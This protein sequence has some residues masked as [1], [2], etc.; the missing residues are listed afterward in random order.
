MGLYAPFRSLIRNLPVALDFSFSAMAA[1]SDADP[2]RWRRP[3][4]F[5]LSAIEKRWAI[6]LLL[7]CFVAVWASYLT[8]AY[9]GS[10][11][12]PD[13]LETWTLGRR[14]EWGYPKH[15]PLMGWIARGWTSVFP[16]TDWSLHLMAMVNAAVALWAVDR[17]AARFVTR[18]K[19]VVILLLL[20]LLPVYQ[21]HAQRFNANSV[22]LAIWPIATYCFLRSFE[23][24]SIAWAVAVGVATAIAML[25]KYYSVFLVLSFVFAAVLHPARRDYFISRA[26][27]VSVAAGFA[28]LAPHLYWL[29]STGAA[30]F[31]YALAHARASF[32]VAI[33][34]VFFFLTGLVATLVPAA[35]AWVFIAGY[36][37][38]QLPEEF[39]AMGS[40]LWLIVLVSCG[41]IVFPVAT[42]LAFGTDLP[43][44]W[45]VQG[46]FLFVLPVVCCTRYAISQFHSVNL[47]VL[48]GAVALIAV[49]VAAPVH[50]LYRN[51]HGYEEARN[52]YRPAALELTR[53]WRATTGMPLRAVSG[54]DALAFAAAFYSPD[55][56]YYA[57]PFAYQY[58]WRTPRKATLERGWA[59]LC[60]ADQPDCIPWMRSTAERAGHYVQTQFE[61]QA[62]LLGVPGVK[63]SIVALLVPPQAEPAPSSST[64]SEDFSA[65]RRAAE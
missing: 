45:A 63:R 48:V 32:S 61:V 28:T 54:D 33:T 50:A 47:A 15:P 5:W 35:L 29:A 65:I 21:F 41:T 22:L 23:E 44:L 36:R 6:P 9:W 11:L 4:I 19:R 14:F 12:H 42:S 64:N 46:L 13:V 17:I 57:R 52:L 38:R 39:R 58:T 27:W 20:M 56:P 43:S 53:L 26:P 25:G 30:P 1:R 31:D 16:L 51:T 18:E 62:K 10:S 34:E 24:R 60:F 59:A 2:A 8:I 49:F 7:A 40:G 3:F 55:H 37:L